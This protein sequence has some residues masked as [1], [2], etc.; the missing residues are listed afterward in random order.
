M[1]LRYPDYYEKFACIADACEDT[2]CAGW[3]IDLDD[4]TYEYYMQLPGRFGDHIRSCIKEY[5]DSEDGRYEKH[6]FYLREGKRCPFLNEKNLCDIILQLGEDAIS[7]VCTHTPRNYLEYGNAR[8]ISI[9]PGCGEAGRWIL[10]NRD[11]QRFVEKEINDS[12]D[13]EEDAKDLKI[14]EAVRAARD[15]SIE[16][17]QD[18]TRGIPERV[19]AFLRYAKQ[20]QERFNYETFCTEP[21]PEQ[22]LSV[23][24]PA[25]KEGQFALFRQR[26]Q[27]FSG[28]ES[29]NEEWQNYLDGIRH[30]FFDLPDGALRYQEKLVQFMEYISQE[31]REY[32]Y[33]QILVYY[34]FLLLA[35]SVDDLN[36]WGRAQLVAASFLMIR[37]MGMTRFVYQDGVF[38]KED[39]VDVLR[40]Y[41]KEVEHS[42]ENLDYLEEE[43]LFEEVYRLEELCSQA[44]F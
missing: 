11:K 19:C 20:I 36:F 27:S 9:S 29:I 35:R 18:R 12:L 40:I 30:L 38:L 15:Y 43:F 5:G 41:A 14:A 25:K 17:L 3:E 8:E 37:D 33:E 10:G 23:F 7:Y 24:S 42:Q 26:M 34:A 2:C 31:D 13:F 16:L 6:G 39:Q 32:E 28:L 1:I 21:D 4:S 22:E 44:V